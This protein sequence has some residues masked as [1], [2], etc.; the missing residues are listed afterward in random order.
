MSS[1]ITRRINSSIQALL[2]RDY[3]S[4]LVH[5]FPALD[6][7]G[8]LRRPKE[9]VGSRIKGFLS[10]EETLILAIV[11][12]GRFRTRGSKFNGMTFAKVIYDFGR[13]SIA[14]E[15]E[16]DPRLRI[17]NDGGLEIGEVWTLPSS[18]ITALCAVV[19]ASPECA[20]ENFDPN[21]S[22]DLFGKTWQMN[23]LCGAKYQLQALVEEVTKQPNFFKDGPLK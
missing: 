19:I 18:Y 12:N 13:T 16:L 4:A 21:L 9:G 11:S 6:K 7:V 10:D 1:A 20:S 8:K 2:N 15:G 17:T 23:E 5:F 22:I 3:E 14:H